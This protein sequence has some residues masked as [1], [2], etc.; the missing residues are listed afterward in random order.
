MRY[1]TK[2]HLINWHYIEYRTL[3]LSK[4]INFLTGETGAGKST[5]LDALQLVI[6]GDLRGH[7]FNKAANENSQ[8]KL[9]EYLRGMTQDNTDEGRKCIRDN[10]D[11]NSYIAIEVLNS[12]TKENFCLGIVFEVRKDSNNYDHIFFKLKGPLPESGFIKNKEYL[13]IK[14][15]KEEY[16]GLL[17]AYTREEYNQHFLYEYMGKLKK[18]FFDVFKRSVAFKPPASIEEFIQKFICDDTKIDVEDMVTPIRIY[19]KIEKEAEEV[20]T[21]IKDLQVISDEYEKFEKIR[22]QYKISKFIYGRSELELANIK[23]TKLREKINDAKQFIE[24]E[25]NRSKRIED[26]AKKLEEDIDNLKDKIE[27]SQEIVLRKEINDLNNKINEF[28]VIQR[29]FTAEAIKFERWINC[30]QD[31]SLIYGDLDIDTEQYKRDICQMKLY[32]LQKES[33]FELNQKLLGISQLITDKYKH[34]VAQLSKYN[35][36]RK[37]IVEELDRLLKGIFYP[38]PIE[39]LKNILETRLSESCGIDIKVNILADLIEVKDEKWLDAIEGYMNWQKLYLIVEPQYYQ[40]AINIYNSLDK[41]KYYDAGIIDIEKI[42]ESKYTIVKNSLAE[43]II[44]DNKY[45]RIYIDYLLG[46]VVKCENINNIRKYRTAITREC[47][48]YKSYIA[49]RLNP[50]LYLKNRCIGVKSRK[51]RLQNLNEDLKL[52]DIKIKESDE[53]EFKLKGYLNLKIYSNEEIEIKLIEQ[54]R[55]NK[56]SILEDEKRKKENEL[57]KIDL[58]YVQR[59]KESLNNSLIK[60]EDLG[61]KVKKLAEEIGKK[62]SIVEEGSKQIIDQETEYIRIRKM[63]Y[64]NYEDK[65]INSI[66]EKKFDDAANR[67]KNYN[68]ILTSY[69]EEYKSFDN[70]KLKQFKNVADLRQEYCI[71]NSLTWETHVED[72]EKYKEH[73]KLLVDTKLP[74]YIEKI[75]IQ[76]EKAYIAF[77]TDLLS[78]LKD[79]IDKTE[80]QVTFI[81]RSLEKMTFGE[82]RYKFIVRPKKKYIDFYNMLKHDFLGMNL[83]MSLFEEKYKDQIE[84]LFNLIVNTTQNLTGNDMEQLRKQID[85][86]TDYK[87]YLEFDMEQKI[88]M[89]KSD[90]SKTLTK[91]SGGETQSPF[92][93]AVIAAFVNHYRIYNLKD[94]NTM[95]LII[96][97]EAFSKMDEEHAIISIQLLRKLG[98]Q[99]I[100]AAPDDKIPVIG[101]NVDKILYVKNENKRRITITEFED[102]EIEKLINLEI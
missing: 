93:I 26:D 72:N 54:E 96:F 23:S 75:N 87:T 51:L 68:V 7:Y 20:K 37:N 15:L 60:K 77:K 63:L 17:K 67:L 79:A 3:D 33:F 94:N 52:L 34:I 102:K 64:E 74:E 14:N 22:E 43:E 56:I 101:P 41:S 2:L 58:F 91:N 78:K 61:Q 28:K 98:F 83:T 57:S 44:T 25:S 9:I 65:W 27:K 86:Y 50:N 18:G 24:R 21:Q 47:F 36:D 89:Y 42:A 12:E 73:L 45:A 84:F 59:L 49:R 38:S 92:F 82:K 13:S 70:K 30:V 76:K 29:I 95:R 35:E 53:I 32:N 80:E 69:E 97:D 10:I 19:K 48:L 1:I 88:G 8:R 99:A 16:G 71:K 11:F 46:R 40:E 5:I 62:K 39:N 100:I 6:L 85:I 90:L 66:G 55:V 4:G 81:N 31:L